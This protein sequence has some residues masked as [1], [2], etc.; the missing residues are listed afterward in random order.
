MPTDRRI[1]YAEPNHRQE[2]A[3]KR[4]EFAVGELATVLLSSCRTTAI[5]QS[6]IRDVRKA[7]API[8]ADVLA[9]D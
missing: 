2:I 8:L 3:L 6:A 4:I 7:V 5:A 1:T 9:T